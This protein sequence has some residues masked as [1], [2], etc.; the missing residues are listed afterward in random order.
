[1]QNM[2]HASTYVVSMCHN[3][4]VSESNLDNVCNGMY[5]YIYRYTDVNSFRHLIG[6]VPPKNASTL[7]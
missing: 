5:I 4:Y 1:M 7:P 2:H 6:T 3:I